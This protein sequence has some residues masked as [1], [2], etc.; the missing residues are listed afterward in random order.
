MTPRFSVGEH[1]EYSVFEGGID[2]AYPAI[3]MESFEA[4]LGFNPSYRLQNMATA[5]CVTV[6]VE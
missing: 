4:D 6:I 1:V 5:Q 3:V 2:A